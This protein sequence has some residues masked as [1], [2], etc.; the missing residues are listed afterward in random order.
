MLEK[1]PAFL[2]NKYI[3]TIIVFVVWLL[4]FDQNNFILQAQN[5][6]DLWEME[7]EKQYYLEVI[8]VTKNDLEE[9]TS[10]MNS[11]ERFAREKYLMKRDNEEVF[12]FVVE[13]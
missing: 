10:D 12:V 11:L 8:E 13:E 9:L 3:I 5:K 6:W 7:E 1:I 4:F 2:K